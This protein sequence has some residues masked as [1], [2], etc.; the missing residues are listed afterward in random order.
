MKRALAYIVAAVV[1]CG[2][3]GTAK[4]AAAQYYKH[5]LGI[6]VGN[7]F[8]AD[9]KTFF[10]ERFAVDANLGLVNP[11]TMRYQF[12]IVS[13]AC[14][15]HFA[16]PIPK[17]VPYAGGGLSAGM[18]FGRRRHNTS[19]SRDHS[20]FM[21]VDIPIGV[22]YTLKMPAVVFFEWNPKIQFIEEACF[23]PQSVSLGFRFTFDW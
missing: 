22:E 8:A 18:Q 23:V 9:Y 11:F 16:T 4:P 2:L 14:Q 13:G 21:S 17:L 12:M 5:G 1:T 6:R 7:H 15:Y 19:I 20:F 10:S 3:F